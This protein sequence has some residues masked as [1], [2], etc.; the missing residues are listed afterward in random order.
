LL[1]FFQK[2]LKIGT[3]NRFFFQ[4]FKKS[5]KKTIKIYFDIKKIR[6]YNQIFLN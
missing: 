5:E 1:D 6:K 4:K 3:K 2:N